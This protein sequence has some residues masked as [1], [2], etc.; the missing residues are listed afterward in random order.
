MKSVEEHGSEMA[1]LDTVA[2][3]PWIA[4]GE[5]EGTLPWRHAALLAAGYD[6]YALELA[7]SSAIDIHLAV[8]LR[9]RGCPPEIAARILL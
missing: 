7:L 5:H 2:N 1:S 8:G 3:D 6:R 4:G 9:D